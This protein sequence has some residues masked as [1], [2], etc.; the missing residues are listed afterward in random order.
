[1][2]RSYLRYYIGWALI[3][4]VGMGV[5]FLPYPLSAQEGPLGAAYRGERT[6]A[7][8]CTQ[9][10]G[11]GGQGDGPMA[12][13]VPVKIPNFTEDSYMNDRSPQELFTTITNGKMENLMPPWGDTLSVGERWDLVAYIWSL[14]LGND[15]ITMS[16]EVF[17]RAC[18]SCHGNDGLGTEH[19]PPLQPLSDPARLDQTEAGLRSL[20]SEAPHPPVEGLT[21]TEIQLAAVAARNFGLGVAIST[22]T[23]EGNGV[24]DVVVR[25][26]TSGQAE[27][28]QIV[29]L[30]VF[31]RDS[32]VA[33]RSGE[34]DGEGF[35]RF[36][37]MPTDAAWVYLAEVVYD[38]LP[39]GGDVRQFEPDSNALE[40]PVDVYESGATLDDIRVGRSHWVLSLE[41]PTSLDV[42]EL[43]ALSN[44]DNRVYGGSRGE[45]GIN[46]VLS[47]SLPANAVNVSIDGSELGERFILE[48]GMIIDTLPFPPGERQ[49][50]FRY[51]LPVVDGKTDLAHA[52]HY[53]VDYLNLLVPD[54]GME[55]D[56]P[57]WNE[58]ES[59]Q[60]QGGASYLN[61]VIENASAGAN[62]K[63]AFSNI[64][65]SIPPPQ[66][67]P[68]EG[69]G[70]IIDA[71]ATPGIS[72]Q[73]YM[74]F[75]ILGGS[76][77][78]LGIGLFMVYRRRQRLDAEAPLL[79]EQQRQYLIQEIAELDDEYEAGEIT[80]ADSEGQRRLLKAQLVA[81]TR[82]DA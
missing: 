44:T 11:P 6:F 40:I 10:H 63:A 67:P 20:V 25:N 53:P 4:L 39:Y 51:S 23:V 15:E 28:N 43:Y 35:A 64:E 41:R 33:E 48:E 46:R 27:G 76:I 31:E 70:Q 17:D 60:A 66:T 32:F 72:G 74:P 7:Q 18:S 81:L 13:Q 45:G 16:T 26:G 1:M 37:G 73:T 69:G 59:M 77:L 50:L 19:E 38:A 58:M 75:L 62:P 42:G 56:A 79:R 3:L 29:R 61:F 78:V 21:D 54:V 82:E 24:I 14:H 30:L 36:T 2:R 68:E 9:C 52:I 12:D 71:N 65:A 47:F 57:D 5:F 22:A 80:K 8:R 55:I 34:T 49:V